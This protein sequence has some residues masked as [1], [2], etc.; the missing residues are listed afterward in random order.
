MIT[1]PAF[2]VH[3]ISIGRVIATKIQAIEIWRMARAVPLG[4]FERNGA[5]TVSVM[6]IIVIASGEW[7]IV[8]ERGTSV[9]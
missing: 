1:F 7:L 3:T 2:P 6:I 8:R 5:V 9:S 4:S